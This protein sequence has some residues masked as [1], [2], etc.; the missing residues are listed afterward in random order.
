MLAQICAHYLVADEVHLL[1]HHTHVLS[2]TGS[3][4]ADVGSGI[5]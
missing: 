5:R 1:G 3:L 4:T 2:S